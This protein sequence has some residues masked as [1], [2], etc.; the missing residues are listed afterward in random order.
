MISKIV[1]E[2]TPQIEVLNISKHRFWLLFQEQEYFLP[3]EAFPWFKEAK[4]GD[5]LNVE[6]LHSSHLY[7]PSLDVD[8]EVESIKSPEK[9]PLVYRL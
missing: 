2:N 6:L 5:I 7:W 8:L 9:Y 4:I 3:F 1:G